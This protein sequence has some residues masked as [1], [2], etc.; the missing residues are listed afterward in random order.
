MIEIQGCILGISG[1]GTLILWNLR[2]VKKSQ[3]TYIFKDNIS[4]LPSKCSVQIDTHSLEGIKQFQDVLV[5][6]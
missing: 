3:G 6:Y 4:L 2:E 1:D 5:M